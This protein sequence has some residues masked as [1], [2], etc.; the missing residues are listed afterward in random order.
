MICRARLVELR[1]G[2]TLRWRH[3]LL[4]P[5]MLDHE[6]RCL[7]EALGGDTVRLV[8]QEVYTGLLVPFLPRSLDGSTLRGFR[9]MQE[10][11]RARTEV[12]SRA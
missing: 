9:V 6:Y 5:G 2:Q 4:L 10:A 8:Q 12:T 1:V 11:L 3:R 7:I